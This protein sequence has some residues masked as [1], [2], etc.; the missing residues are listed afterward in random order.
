MT[1]QQLELFS[2]YRD[3]V[4]KLAEKLPQW[5][6]SAPFDRRI[7]ATL[8]SILEETGEISGLVSKYYTRVS[9]TG[10]DYYTTPIK[11][12]PYDVYMEIKNKF[13]DEVG[14]LFWVI[15]AGAYVLDLDLLDAFKNKIVSDVKFAQHNLIYYLCY[16]V[17]DVTYIDTILRSYRPKLEEL[18]LYFASQLSYALVNLVLLLNRDYNITF[19]EILTH[20]MEKLGFRYD[21]T[22]KRVDGK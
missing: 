13:I 8:S 18:K 3:S 4:V 20:N 11:D 10:I 15:T 5:N 17:S 16:I 6:S 1:E 2:K 12:L 7:M 9:K 21:D 22:G 19:E 14:D